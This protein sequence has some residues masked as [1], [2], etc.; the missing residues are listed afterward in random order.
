MK[1]QNKKDLELGCVLISNEINYVT[2]EL[3]KFDNYDNLLVQKGIKALMNSIVIA[4]VET[5]LDYDV[6]DS[7]DKLINEVNE[8][9]FF[10]QSK[11]TTPSNNNL[12]FALHRINE[13]VRGLQWALIYNDLK[14]E[15]TQHY[16]IRLLKHLV[17]EDLTIYLVKNKVLLN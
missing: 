2:L 5:F 15:H 4:K 8:L 9:P 12:K 7:N 11:E 3:I 13:C 10:K 6:I 1:N 17:K 16:L 14:D